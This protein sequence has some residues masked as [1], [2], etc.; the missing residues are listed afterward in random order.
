MMRL[1]YCYEVVPDEESSAHGVDDPRVRRWQNDL[2]AD[3]MID[4]ADIVYLGASR[5]DQPASEVY[6]RVADYTRPVGHADTARLGEFGALTDALFDALD[7]QPL[8][9]RDGLPTITIRELMISIADQ[10]LAG[11]LTQRAQLCA[12]RPLD[13]DARFVD[14]RFLP[15]P[16]PLHV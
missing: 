8:D 1:R 12:S 16:S 9:S 10:F 13:L 2:A 4:G 6:S 7:E 3:D 15:T 14:L 5:A 11:G